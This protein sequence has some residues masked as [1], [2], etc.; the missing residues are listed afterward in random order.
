[1]NVIV[2]PAGNFRHCNLHLTNHPLF[3]VEQ[4]ERERVQ[5][6]TQRIPLRIVVQTGRH[7]RGWSFSGIICYPATVRIG[8]GVPCRSSNFSDQACVCCCL[9]LARTGHPASGIRIQLHS[10]V[11]SQE[12]CAVGTLSPSRIGH[13]KRHVRAGP[14]EYL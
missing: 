10:E 12:P 11:K 14:I 6:S 8:E 2:K 4:I 13:S 9:V 1:M 7:H 5:T 3:L